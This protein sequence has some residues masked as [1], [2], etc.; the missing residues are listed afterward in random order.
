MTDTQVQH[1]S[2]IYNLV[3]WGRKLQAGFIAF[4]LVLVAIF[5]YQ[6][7][8]ASSHPPLILIATARTDVAIYTL[9][10]PEKL[11]PSS[12][13]INSSIKLITNS[14]GNEISD[15][16]NVI[17]DFSSDNP[18][19]NFEPKQIILPKLE[20]EEYDNPHVVEIRSISRLQGE[21]IN[22]NVSITSSNGS[23]VLFQK[24]IPVDSTIY[25]PYVITLAALS[26]V[27]AILS[28]IMQIRSFR[29]K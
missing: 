25:N 24:T 11:I 4:V 7:W 23:Q 8:Q 16:E 9:N 20:L 5:I 18:N 29:S 3:F 17:I 27:S 21:L 14:S 6:Y 10:M 22:I 26:F 19:I 12:S 28:S 15:S 13:G 2:F 1:G